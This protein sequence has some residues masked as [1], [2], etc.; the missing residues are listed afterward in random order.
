VR[1]DAAIFTR[2]FLL[3]L[4]VLLLCISLRAL[5]GLCRYVVFASSY[6]RA[7]ASSAVRKT[8]PRLTQ[9][10]ADKK[11]ALLLL[12]VR[13]GGTIGPSKISRHPE[14]RGVRPAKRAQ[15]RGDSFRRIRVV[16]DH[17][18]PPRGNEVVC[19]RN[20]ALG[21]VSLPAVACAFMRDGLKE[22]L[23]ALRTAMKRY[24]RLLRCIMALL[25]GSVYGCASSDQDI[26]VLSH[27]PHRA[28]SD[29]EVLSRIKAA[30]ALRCSPDVVEARA[31]RADAD[32]YGGHDFR[33][34]GD[35]DTGGLS[36]DSGKAQELEAADELLIWY[37]GPTDAEREAA[38]KDPY[39]WPGDRFVAVAWH[40]GTIQILTG[41][42]PPIG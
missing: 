30:V 7:S 40:K 1:F 16:V 3:R 25:V 13:R 33:T 34:G 19:S 20:N 28:M 37:L 39:S 41:H 26:T 42:V 22:M 15:W 5:G 14:N 18:A 29:A 36:L 23:T 6:P 2:N 35:F 8:G 9:T 10:G 21:A 32:Y 12:R 31:C 17:T 4:P 24:S 27:A 38:R 11:V